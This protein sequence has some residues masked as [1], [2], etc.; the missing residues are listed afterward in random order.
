[1][2]RGL[3]LFAALTAALALSAIAGAAGTG[4]S[5]ITF[6][7]ATGD[8]TSAPDITNVAV[9]GD[10]A[11]GTITFA[12]SATG[13]ALPTADGSTRF[14]DLWLNTDRNDATGDSDGSE[15]DLF[16][17]NDST[18][19]TQW[20]W[21][22]GT[23]VNGAWQ[24]V[25]QSSTMHAGG[26]GNQFAIQVNKSDLGGATSFDVYATSATVDASGNVV[27]HDDAPDQ[28]RWVYD[29]AGPSKTVT[30]LSLPVIGKPVPA[31]AKATAGKRLTVS[32]PVSVSKPAS[33]AGAKVV[34]TATV[35][36]KSVAHTT[37]LAGGAVKVSFLVPKTAKG[38]PVKVVVTVTPASSEDDNGTWV[39]AGTGETGIQATVVKGGTASKSLSTTVH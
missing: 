8:S 34:G 7:D 37:S 18:D 26:A 14:V 3:T 38:K 11:S 29:L 31:P 10:A 22:I 36:G 39:D 13:L 32:F 15:Y 19:P 20:S 9:Q 27:A 24:E 4:P 21:D 25:A 1:M 12:I 16:V 28:G 2:K 33:L 6:A 30:A 5:T 17:A 35:G 23:F